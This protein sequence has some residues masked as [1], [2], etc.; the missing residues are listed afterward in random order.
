MKRSIFILLTTFLLVLVL[1]YLY[2]QRE[3]ILNK[4]YLDY[5]VNIEYPFFNIKGIDDDIIRYIDKYRNKEYQELYI[6]YDYYVYDDKV[7]LTM[8]TY[9]VNNN[10]VFS[11]EKNF[12]VNSLSYSNDLKYED[13]Y[14]S[15]TKTS[16][17]IALTFD[18]GPN[19]NTNRVLSILEKYNVKAT[20]FVLGSNID[21]HGDIIIR[22]N[23]LGMEIGNHMYSHKLVSRLSDFEIE[24]E[25]DMVDELIYHIIGSKTKFVRP[26]YGSYN[27]RLKNI[28]DR[29]I[30][31]WSN[32]TLDWKYHNSRRIASRLIN[33]VRDGDI[34]LMHDIYRSTANSLEI[35]IP[36]LLKNN[37][38][39]VT[40]SE[41]FSNK[42]IIFKDGDIYYRAR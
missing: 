39:F 7:N 18:D 35:I 23:D 41:L 24:S 26:S 14:E 42:G 16:K 30:I 12:H 4:K 10:L 1:L 8:Y 5:N 27:K 9:G 32:D 25:I 37:Y 6:D 36:Y 15:N 20:F 40:V 3:E 22:M 28:I 21:G 29:P 13:F 2:N 17:M 11:D 34:I 31:M 33:S 38:K 19:Y